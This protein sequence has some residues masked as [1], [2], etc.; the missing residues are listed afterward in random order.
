MAR[1]RMSRKEL[2]EKDDI[3]SA[4]ETA[5]SFGFEHRRAILNAA[6]V[7]LIVILALTG[8]TLYSA[9]VEAAAQNALGDVL[10]A[11]NTVVA[12][13]TE[14]RLLNTISAAERVATEH[15]GTQAALVARYYAAIAH[16][17]MGN[18]GQADG[19]LT[20]LVDS[21]DPTIRDQARF[22]RAEMFK[23][24]G[25]LEQ[26]IAEY[27]ILADSGDYS[28]SAVLFELGRL[29]EAVSM[30]EEAIEYY[31]T[32]TV[33]YPTSPYRQDADRSIRRIRAEL[34]SA[35]S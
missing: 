23:E 14:A 1:G 17:E 27:E 34:E 10:V 18:T 24:R 30:P 28:R 32:L 12:G 26:A 21:D 6:G 16:D 25:D 33:E 2:T 4:L 8:W 5:V 20:E 15:S 13:D 35:S 7:V 11:Y 29:H 9:S 19:L 22:A 31:E 3:T